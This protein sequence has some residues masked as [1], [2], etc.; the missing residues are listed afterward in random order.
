[1]PKYNKLVLSGKWC[2][3]EMVLLYW[4]HL[5]V[6]KIRGPKTEPGG[7]A[8]FILASPESYPFIEIIFL[9]LEK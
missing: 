8:Q 5:C 3:Y 6:L 4:G 2:T 7:T 9:R 1:M